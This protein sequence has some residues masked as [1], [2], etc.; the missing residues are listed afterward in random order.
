MFFRLQ[1]LKKKR[2]KEEKKVK[3]IV[4]KIKAGHFKFTTRACAIVK[5]KTGIRY[6]L[7]V[8]KVFAGVVNM[9][10]NHHDKVFIDVV[11]VA[12]QLGESKLI[13]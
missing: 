4:K 11:V 6:P 1:V 7:I 3:E 5:R 9:I 2:Q 13:I 12:T 10:V 8:A